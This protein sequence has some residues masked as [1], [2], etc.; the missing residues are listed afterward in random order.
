M[1]KIG[2]KIKNKGCVEK[3]FKRPLQGVQTR[4]MKQTS[5]ILD[6][7]TAVLR[8]CLRSLRSKRGGKYEK[9]TSGSR[10]ETQFPYSD[11]KRSVKKDQKSLMKLETDIQRFQ[12]PKKLSLYYQQ[13]DSADSKRYTNRLYKKCAKALKATNRKQ[14]HESSPI[15]SLCQIINNGGSNGKDSLNLSEATT[16]YSKSDRGSFSLSDVSRNFR[17]THID[18]M[19]KIENNLFENL[20]KG[21]LSL[22][23]SKPKESLKP[24]IVEHTNKML[25]FIKEVSQSQNV[26]EIESQNII[27]QASLARESQK[28]AELIKF[29]NMLA[30]IT[31]TAVEALNILDEKLYILRKPDSRF[32]LLVN[33]IKKFVPSFSVEYMNLILT[34][35]EELFKIRY[36]GDLPV[37]T[38]NCVPTDQESLDRYKPL[39]I[40]SL[41][42]KLN[43]YLVRYEE[44]VTENFSKTLNIKYLTEEYLFS[45][46]KRIVILKGTNIDQ[47]NKQLN[48]TPQ[49][50]QMP[51]YETPNPTE[52]PASSE[53]KTIINPRNVVNGNDSQIIDYV[54]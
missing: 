40:E 36:S 34:V 20:K 46:L 50:Q 7:N 1:A 3:R 14:V 18:V 17:R 5:I 29:K 12:S 6:D 35:N 2:H 39:R 23:P 16:R 27:Q 28:A 32:D 33:F 11:K 21:N 26:A 52:T 4:R 44:E 47:E 43:A 30:E 41:K 13:S 19:N 45:R 42:Q 15:L 37:L 25:S 54:S 38:A 22:K 24:V 49:P 31:T 53:E 8:G 10:L 9:K 51:Q 48:K